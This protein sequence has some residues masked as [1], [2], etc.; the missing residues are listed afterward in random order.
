MLFH[1]PLFRR[2]PPPLDAD[3]DINYCI[4]IWFVGTGGNRWEPMGTGGHDQFSSP[5]DLGYRSM[6][7]FHQLQNSIFSFY[8]YIYININSIKIMNHNSMV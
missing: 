5:I 6:P 3:L 8:K 4:I 7:I 1:R 2:P